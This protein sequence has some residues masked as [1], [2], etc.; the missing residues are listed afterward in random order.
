VA[1]VTGTEQDPQRLSTQVTA[2]Q[3]AGAIIC[4]SNAAAARLAGMLVS[5]EPEVKLAKET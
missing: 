5:S 1:S 4:T 3:A 2:L